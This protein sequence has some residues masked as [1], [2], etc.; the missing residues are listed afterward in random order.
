VPCSLESRPEALKERLG[1]RPSAGAGPRR[2]HLFRSGLFLKP[3]PTLLK[4]EQFSNPQWFK[5][6]C[7]PNQEQISLLALLIAERLLAF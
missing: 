2:S 6:V 4:E 5:K 1:K 3:K 7:D